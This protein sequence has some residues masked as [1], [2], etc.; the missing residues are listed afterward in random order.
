MS[1][2]NPLTP[3]CFR[4]KLTCH[5]Y[6]CFP[7]CNMALF[8]WFLSRLSLSRRRF[9][10]TWVWIPCILLE[11]NEEADSIFDVTADISSPT[12]PSCLKSERA[13]SQARCSLLWCWRE[14]QTRPA[15][16]T[17]NVTTDPWLL[18]RLSCFI[19]R[20]AWEPVLLSQ[21][22]SLYEQ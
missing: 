17:Q 22:A 8:H 7:A 10:C 11:F 12:I 16:H 13:I 14:F 19:L 18:L 4:W 6:H 21:K 5:S 2:Y 3:P 9:R 20:P 15:C 1:F